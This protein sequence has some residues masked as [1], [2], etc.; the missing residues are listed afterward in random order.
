M[1]AKTHNTQL[2]IE[3]A[4]DSK[5]MEQLINNFNIATN[6]QA[7]KKDWFHEKLTRGNAEHNLRKAGNKQGLFLVRESNS[8]I[9]GGF[10]LSLVH[11]NK[12]QHFQ[13][14]YNKCLCFC[15]EGG[16][17]FVGLDELISYYRNSSNG[18]PTNL[19][20]SCKGNPL[21]MELRQ[22]GAETILHKCIE[23]RVSVESL[24]KV[25]VHDS[26]PHLNVRNPQ[27]RTVLQEA[28]I[29]GL[30]SHVSEL[31]KYKAD[32][33]IRDA[34]GNSALHLACRF[35]Q[36]SI[37]EILLTEFEDSPQVRCFNNGWVPLHEACRYGN[38]EC[39][40]KL[41]E[42]KAAIYP[43]SSIGETP[44]EIARQYKHQKCVKTLEC[45]SVAKCVY[46]P[47]Q[48]L[49]KQVDRNQAVEYLEKYGK[50]Q[51][52]CFL[53]RISKRCN[54]QPVL[55][56][57]NNNVV[58]NYEI[59]NKNHIGVGGKLSS[60]YFIDDGP[61]FASL[62]QLVAY[63][64]VFAD[65]LP[66]QLTTP[67][68]PDSLLR[69]SSLQVSMKKHPQR[70]PPPVKPSLPPKQPTNLFHAAHQPPPQEK[71]RQISR[72]SIRLGRELGQGEF[73]EVLMGVWMCDVGN[74]IPVALK[75][76]RGDQH[77]NKGNIEFQR[78]AE[79]MMKLDH[80]C[81]V[82]LYGICQ[83]DNL[84]MVQELVAMGSALDYILDYPNAVNQTDFKLWA[85]QIASG[86]TYLEEKGFVH[87][88]LALRNILL[89][90]KQL[91]KIS[92]FGL[93]RAVKC[94]ENGDNLYTASTGGRWPVKWYA[95]ESIYY[96]TFSSSSDVWSYGVTLW[97]IFTKGEQ[98][99][100]E[101][102]GSD[103]VNY[104]E[105]GHRLAQPEGCPNK[106]YKIMLQCWHAEAKQ[107]PTFAHLHKKFRSDPEYFNIY[108]P[109]H[110][111]PT[112]GL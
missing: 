50:L 47:A 71:P 17:P 43:R 39:V 63:F 15:I 2:L 95:L 100:P 89:S 66:T 34:E 70:P 109:G 60:W 88:D 82:K 59:K 99:Y 108:V 101:M 41:L 103:V 29:A 25:L 46:P 73:G 18:L 51:D 81:I 33:R 38:N 36:A 40:V 55:T 52:G 91:V 45:W 14:Q 31:L 110:K 22:Y 112:T 96:G 84:M 4:N 74:N 107:R 35:N 20:V 30:Q 90:S 53:I 85:A 94:S 26:C 77:N 19:Q 102:G 98:P 28:C 68:S 72:D 5:K 23:D 83:S 44:L 49:H 76:L 104:I 78:E 69:R 61:L 67:V 48:W 12:A 62:E 105:K 93:S 92:D 111:Q 87:R 37:A 1:N 58:F 11:K 3:A 56:M 42:H 8:S 6:K 54:N 21:K 106:I 10:V 79:V 80:P 24:R 64:F 9:S 86:M 65:G 16:P 32:A 27:G 13:I 7:T 75:T 57:A 97:E